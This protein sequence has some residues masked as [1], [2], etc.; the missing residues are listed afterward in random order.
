MGA[1]QRTA[2]RAFDDISLLLCTVLP[3]LQARPESKAEFFHA[4]SMH[5]AHSA[6]RLACH[7]D[8]TDP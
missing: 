2:G 3:V 7:C 4:A 8:N 5:G 6:H 1:L